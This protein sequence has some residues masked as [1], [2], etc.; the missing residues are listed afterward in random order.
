MA[1]TS[2]S[3]VSFLMFANPEKGDPNSGISIALSFAES[4]SLGCF[5]QGFLDRFDGL[6]N[7]LLGLADRLVGPSFCAK[8]VIAGQCAGSFPD[9]TFR[10]VCLATHDNDSL[11]LGCFET[12]RT[13]NSAL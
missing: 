8:P 5:L 12:Q 13:Q 1:L 6:L 3:A 7:S 9:P 4:S 10:H 11:F 2:S